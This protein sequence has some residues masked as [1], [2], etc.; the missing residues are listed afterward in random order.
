M[1]KLF[2]THYYYPGI[3][4]WKNIMNLPEQ[5]AFRIAAEIA[6]MDTNVSISQ[7]SKTLSENMASVTEQLKN[8]VGN[9]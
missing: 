6:A 4:S 2:I 8:I 5:E 3:D 7:N 1:D 9:G